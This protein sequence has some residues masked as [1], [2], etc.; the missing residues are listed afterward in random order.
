[1]N[2]MKRTRR[3]IDDKLEI[4]Y[5]IR[6]MFIFETIKKMYFKNNEILEFMSRPIIY[7]K[8]NKIE[9]DKITNV[10]EA[11]LKQSNKMI[12]NETETKVIEEK[13]NND[14]KKENQL[15]KTYK[16]AY[17]YNHN[18]LINQINNLKNNDFRSEPQTE[19]IN[20]LKKSLD[21]I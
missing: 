3:M 4:V 20:L 5:Y 9:E 19:L 1:M 14:E 7:L 21:G 16:Y 10:N 6:S 13:E 15:K 17:K 8:N 2:L 12:N 11:Y 18:L